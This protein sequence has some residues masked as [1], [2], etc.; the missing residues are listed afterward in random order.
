M[1]PSIGY[2]SLALRL[3]F[4]PFPPFF[5]VFPKSIRLISI[6]LKGIII[7]KKKTYFVRVCVCDVVTEVDCDS[8]VA[9]GRRLL[10]KR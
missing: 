4:P 1:M 9:A 6:T 7:I 10:Y 5:H 3:F 8:S 2:R